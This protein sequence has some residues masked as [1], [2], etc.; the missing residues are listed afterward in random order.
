MQ[1]NNFSKAVN[2]AKLQTQRILNVDMT[3]DRDL[4]RVKKNLPTL[5]AFIDK[6]I[7]K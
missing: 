1:T 4:Q 7:K 2:I 3:R 5:A 6:A